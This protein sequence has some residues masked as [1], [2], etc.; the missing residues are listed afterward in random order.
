MIP[1]VVQMEDEAKAAKAI[2]DAANQGVEAIQKLGSFIDRAFGNTISNSIGLIGDKLAYYRLE[3]AISLKDKVEKRLKEK[4]ISASKFVPISFGLPLI[5]KATIE[6]D[7]DLHTKWANLL[8]NAMDPTYKGSIKRSFVGI[9]AELEPIDAQIAQLVV[10]EYLRSPASSRDQQLFDLARLASALGIPRVEAEISVR[11]LLRLGVFK[12][13]VVSSQSISFG[14]NQLSSYKD[15]D[16]FGVT[17]L[18][19][20][21]VK[22]V[23]SS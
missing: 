22:S 6:D 12:P 18:G 4:G 13:G 10:A 15:A 17:V 9:L 23:S 21:F 7:E 14:N 16:L 3:R 8:A 20:E 5:E 2:A 1:Q 19:I 11:N